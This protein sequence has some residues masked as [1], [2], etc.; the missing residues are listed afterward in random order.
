M[1]VITSVIPLAKTILAAA[2]EMTVA[3]AVKRMMNRR[4]VLAV[5]GASLPLRIADC[6]FN[7][8]VHPPFAPSSSTR[9]EPC[10]TCTP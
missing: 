10:S 6:G 8:V 5:I 4:E 2:A 7:R 3:R 1:S 9:M